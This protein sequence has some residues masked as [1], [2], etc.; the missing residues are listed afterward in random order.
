MST[1]SH[2]AGR[3]L[4]AFALFLAATA[5]VSLY[6]TNRG[7][8]RMLDFV[9]EPAI[10]LAVAIGLLALLLAGRL[11]RYVVLACLIAAA[12]NLFRLWPYTVLAQ[13]QLPLPDDVNGMS[14]A[15]VLSLNVLQTNTQY[16]RVA[17]LIEREDPDVVLLMETNKA[18]VK[19]LET[20]LSRYPYTLE[21]PLDNK[22][23]MTFATRLQ[24]EKAEM[25]ANTNSNTPTLYATLRTAD[26][27]RFELIGLHPRPPLPGESTAERDRNIARAGAV[28]PDR[29]DN[30]L[31]IGDFND[32]PWSRTT[33]EFVQSGGYRD[34]RVGRG[35][36]PTF[37]ASFAFG[38]W[39][40]DQLF[41]K[42]GVK[43]ESF[44]ILD[45]VGADH[46]PVMADVCAGPE[47]ENL[48]ND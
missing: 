30:V 2:W 13:A 34:P 38:G 8:V 32:V 21:M 43:V 19:A 46:L 48:P 40:L 26:E 15:R 18:W 42:N 6:P 39:P 10:W 12:V 22:Y 47:F 14:C 36:F 28:T 31:A 25:V 11:R 4:L 23:G 29:L 5:L 44:A 17:Q 3:I 7:L 1:S 24:V 33:H 9:R 37:P 45:D 41:V 27:A 35:S 16:D 20:P